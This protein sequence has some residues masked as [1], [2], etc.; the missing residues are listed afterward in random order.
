MWAHFRDIYVLRTFQQY[1]ELFNPMSFDPYNCLLKIQ[2]SIEIL[3]PK[4]GIH[5]GVWGGSFPH[6]FLHSQEYEMWLPSF[7]LGPHL[8]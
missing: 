4:V 2:K 3:T 1:K 5:L 7:T 8:C 6:T